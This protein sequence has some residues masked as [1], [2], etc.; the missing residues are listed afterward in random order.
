MDADRQTEI[1]EKTSF[2]E[3]W[4]KNPS[5][6]FKAAL[7]VFPTNTPKALWTATNWPLDAEVLKLK[8]DLEDEFGEASFL[9]SKNELARDIWEKAKSTGDPY[10]Y[11]RLAK[12]YADVR[13]FIEKPNVAQTNIQMI[14]PKVIQVVNHGSDA[15]WEKAAQK[16]QS[17][18]LSVSRSRN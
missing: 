5:D 4:L 3:Q 15:D 1:A 9:P 17:E 7:L 13:G 6:P 11:E 16:Q 8:R 12:L 18:L 10:A 14:A 2:A